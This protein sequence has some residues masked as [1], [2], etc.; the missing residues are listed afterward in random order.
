MRYS[1]LSHKSFMY[2]YMGKP[3]GVVIVLHKLYI[4]DDEH[5][6]PFM[7]ETNCCLHI[8]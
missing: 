2:A 7:N 5:L 1:S 6:T 8:E 3:P 4:V